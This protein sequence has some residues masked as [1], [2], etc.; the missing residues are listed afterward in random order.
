MKIIALKR[1]NKKN[2][3]RFSTPPDVMTD[4]SSSLKAK[5]SCLVVYNISCC[6]KYIKK[7]KIMIVNNRNFDAE[8]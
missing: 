2:V 8:D 7:R 1:N 5:S 3:L 4:V 6:E